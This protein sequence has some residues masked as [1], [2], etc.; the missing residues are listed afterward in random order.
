M[1][2]H[3]KVKTRSPKT[4]NRPREKARTWEGVLV[5]IQS[6]EL[7]AVVAAQR[8]PGIALVGSQPQAVPLALGLQVE[9]AVLSVDLLAHPV[10]QL[11]QQLV[12]TLSS[13]LVDAFQAEPVFPI[14]VS[15]AALSQGKIRGTVTARLQQIM[16]I[17]FLMWSPEEFG[18]TGTVCEHETALW[19]RPCDCD[20]ARVPLLMLL[21]LQFCS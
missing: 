8:V 10:L 2:G 7:F 19:T 18:N 9:A 16:R 17:V 4:T 11:H 15:K 1:C 13:Q 6:G 5:S 20:R 14:D 12:V 21:R 3:L